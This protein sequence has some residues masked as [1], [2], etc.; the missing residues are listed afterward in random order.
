VDPATFKLPSDINTTTDRPRL[1]QSIN[2]LLGRVGTMR[3]AFVAESNDKFAPPGT[4]FLF[5]ARFAEYDSYVQDT[6]K[7]RPNLTIDLG[8]R[9]EIRKAPDSKGVA[10]LRPDKPF[11]VGS[12]PSNALR[13]EEGNCLMMTGTTSP[14]L[15]GCWDPFKDGKTSVRANYRLTYDR[16]NTFVFSSFIF[17]TCLD[18][19]LA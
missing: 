7:L 18:R 8:V 9:W 13:W 6:W 11:T 10:I 16:L 14:L 19:Q 1:Q 5:D 4:D 15:S 2:E 3:Q 17:P 12:D